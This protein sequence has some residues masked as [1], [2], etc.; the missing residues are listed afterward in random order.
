[1]EQAQQAVGGASNPLDSQGLYGGGVRGLAALYT[2]KGIMSR[3]NYERHQEG[4][5]PAKPCEIF[6]LIGGTSTGG[7]M[8]IMLGR[9]E[10]DVDECISK[11][12]QISEEIFRERS[13]WFLLDRKARIKGRF[14]SKNLERAVRAVLK[15]RN[16]AENEMLDDGVSRGCKVFVCA[17][18]KDTK[19]VKRLRSYTIPDE[20]NIKPTIVEAALATSAATSFFD[21]VT[22]GFRTF[23]DGGVGAN[24]PV[25]QV[26]QEASNI[27]CPKSGDLKPLVKC[28]VSIGTGN[29]GKAAL[30]YNAAKFAQ[31]LVDLTTDTEFTA[32]DFIARWRGHYEEGR[33]FRFSV[34]HGIENLDLAEYRAQGLIEAAADDYIHHQEQ[35]FK[36]QSCVQNLLKKEI[37]A[38]K[39]I[40]NAIQRFQQSSPLP[41][42]EPLDSEFTVPFDLTGIR[43]T[44]Q[45]IG[46]VSELA[47]LR[48]LLLSNEFNRRKVVVLQGLGGIG[49]TQLAIEFARRYQES[50]SSIFWI[51]GKT[52]EMLLHSLA[53]VTR[54]LASD[55]NDEAIVED[56][57]DSKGIE[58][59]AKEALN[60]FALKGNNKWLIIFDNVDK[61]PSGEV[62]DDEAFPVEDFFPGA[63]QGA[64]IITTRLRQLQELGDFIHLRTMA[65]DDALELLAAS[66]KSSVFKD[67]NDDWNSETLELIKK[68]DGLPLAIVLAGSYIS[69]T[70]MKVARY[71]QLYSEEWGRLQ[72][73]RG[74][75]DYSNGNLSTSL[76]ISYREIART[77]QLAAT[78]LLFLS[79]FDNQD[80]WY[81]LLEHGKSGWD[82]PEWFEEIV[83]DEVNFYTVIGTLSD[84]SFVEK[85]ENAEGYSMHPVVQQWCQGYLKS[86]KNCKSIYIAAFACICNAIP[87]TNEQKF[88]ILQ[89]RLLPHANRLL[90][91]F[92]ENFSVLECLNDSKILEVVSRLGQLYTEQGKLAQAEVVL[93]RTLEKQEKILGADHLSTLDTVRY[94]AQLYWDLTKLAEAEAMILRALKG[95]EKVLDQSDT[96]ILRLMNSLGAVLYL[97][98]RFDEAEVMYQRVIE[99]NDNRKSGQDDIA[100][101]KATN[102]LG[103]I[104]STQGRVED[105]KKLFRKSHEMA[106]KTLGPDHTLTLKS[107]FNLAVIYHREKN[108]DEAEK[109][110]QQ[111]YDGYVKAFGANHLYTMDSLQKLANVLRDQGKLA[112]SEQMYLQVL[113]EREKVYG[114]NHRW[115]AEALQELGLNYK[116]QGRLED[117]DT[118]LLRALKSQEKAMGPTHD[119]T[120]EIV[121]QLS[122]LYLEQGRH[123]EA[124]AMKGRVH[125]PPASEARENP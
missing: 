6:D 66:G 25:N 56:M 102:N 9:L 100:A 30:D 32:K 106:R 120:L 17:T 48:E 64:I 10:M 44:A 80:I 28:F 67:E 15:E 1:M 119:E 8:A 62:E 14:D 47:Q 101:V 116:A 24:N 92:Q 89:Q 13:S 12:S 69:R 83:S 77:D 57:K 118:T 93:R 58:K 114:E 63:D 86:A 73:K 82:A 5:P 49:K 50:F 111:V 88:W 70:G 99:A 41:E 19:E 2:L 79:S 74:P 43:Y 26:E 104:R 36:I 34:D 27:W 122:L 29:T 95:K 3:L 7:L 103:G 115:T 60:W 108:L 65:Q 84:Y 117:A 81:G 68:L 96:E 20:L 98:E 11:F 105:A 71:A 22:I 53:S 18:S 45:F 59:R 110:H 61:D 39:D 75:R 94:L 38:G 51:S 107:L 85:K 112:T 33:Y 42:A 46:R 123:E 21:P 54:R 124:E 87:S 76:T 125:Q 55:Q 121:E 31:A 90:P 52:R 40:E 91:F 78:L 109:I 4:K 113:E 35:K 37:N 72:G 16:V 97:Q 23:V